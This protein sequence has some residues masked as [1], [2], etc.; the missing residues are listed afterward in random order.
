MI[1]SHIETKDV[2]I[3]FQDEARVGQRGTVTRIW[4]P[5]GTRPRII[6]QQQ[7]NA[8]YLFGAVCP[9]NG[10]A[11][12]IIMPKA[13]TEAM[14]HHLEVISDSVSADKHA[15]LVLDRAAW[16][17]TGKLTIPKNISLLPLPPYSPEL[18]PVEQV[19]QQLRQRYLSN[20]S[21]KDYEH[22]VKACCDAWNQ[23]TECPNNIQ[24][25][26]FRKWASLV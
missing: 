1:P 18:N 10:K 2:E 13:N 19:W 23:F 3:W 4:A 15:V 25:L 11:V 14:Q 5:K 24:S 22:I 26:C 6:R 21:F 8:S 16:H 17:L 7:F 20:R 12:G 9:A